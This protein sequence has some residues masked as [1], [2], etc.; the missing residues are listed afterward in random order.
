MALIA[1][2]QVGVQARGAFDVGSAQ[3]T[4]SAFVANGPSIHIDEGDST[5][6]VPDRFARNALGGP[7]GT[8]SAEQGHHGAGA[9]GTLSWGGA[10]DNNGDKAVGGRLAVLPVAGLEL[11][12]GVETAKVGSGDLADLREVTQ[13]VDLALSRDVRPLGGHLD[14]R[15]QWVWLSIDAADVPPLDYANDS[16]GGYVQ[17]AY[18]PTHAPS[19]A[20]RNLEIVGRYDR[21][22]LPDSAEVNEDQWRVTGGLDYWLSSSTV[23]KAAFERQTTRHADGDEVSEN[24]WLAQF[25]MGF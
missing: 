14:V 24:R 1:S 8:T 3:V 12:Y 16:N 6:V 15:G 20:L 17:L 10:E 4:W 11:G 25:A 9:T 19:Q 7:A 18:R 5:A 21:I 2:T 13:S 22:D 23:L